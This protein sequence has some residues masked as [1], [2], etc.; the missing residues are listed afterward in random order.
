MLL[1]LDSFDHYTTPSQKY[2][3]AGVATPLI[4]SSG[5]RFGTNG[6][7]CSD[8]GRGAG[9]T[10]DSPI[11]NFI[12]GV[13]YRP[14]IGNNQ[15]VLAF[16]DGA[17]PQVELRL[18]PSNQLY[19]TRNGTTL[20]TSTRVL[21]TLLTYYIEW[22]VAID[23]AAGVAELVIEGTPEITLSGVDTR[24]A[25]TTVDRFYLQG[26][27]GGDGQSAQFDDLY[28]ADDS[29]SV[30]NDYL[31]DLRV[32]YRAPNGNGNSSQF[33]GS[34]G[35]SIDNYLLVDESVP[36]DDTTYV[37]SPDVGD[38]DTYTYEDLTPTAGSVPGVQI[39][40]YAKRT[41][42]GAR[43]IV[44]V[45]RLSGTETDSASTGLLTDYAYY[46]DVR[47][48]KPGGGAW[49]ITDVNNAEFGVKVSA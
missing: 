9:R 47:E 14:G 23:D 41:D 26:L 33:D 16:R 38:K 22:K 29:G 32:Q 12:I 46:P 13:A 7:V 24:N 45:A 10:L 20:A 34:D 39:I 17:T 2:P 21:L 37:Q 35:N 40:P 30:N 4:N 1:Y 28:L 11:D 18:N 44:T 15:P 3:L 42:A 27:G 6:M 5:G 19:I 48:T 49:S 8:S 43:E 36:D 25:G 31:G